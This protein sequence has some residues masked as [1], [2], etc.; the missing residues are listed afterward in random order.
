MVG[1]IFGIIMNRILFIYFNEE[2][3]IESGEEIVTVW[4]ILIPLI[5]VLGITQFSLLYSSI[6]VLFLMS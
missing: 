4:S 1:T 3:N 5:I 6:L 2:M